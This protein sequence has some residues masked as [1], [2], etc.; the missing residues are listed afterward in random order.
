MPG[1]DFGSP[2]VSGHGGDET[3]LCASRAERGV[4]PQRSGGELVDE[5]TG[6]R[7]PGERVAQVASALTVM[8][9]VTV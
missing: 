5:C 9:A 7:D 3:D 8:C 1:V 6:Q 4:Q 2:G